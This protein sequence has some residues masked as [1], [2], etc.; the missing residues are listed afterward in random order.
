MAAYTQNMS[1]S[2]YVYQYPG[3]ASATQDVAS[4]DTVNLTMTIGTDG[5]YGQGLA[6]YHAALVLT[7]S[8]CTVSP[9][10]GIRPG[11]TIVVTPTGSNQQYSVTAQFTHYAANPVG[12]PDASHQTK[13]FTLT[14][15][16]SGGGG[17]V[18]GG[19]GG[20][21]ATMGLKVYAA[22][23][24]IRLDTK[25]KQIMHYAAYSG[26]LAQNA[27]T[28][29]NVGGGYDITSGDWGIDVT[30]VDLYLKA[31]STVNQIVVSYPRAGSVPYP[32]QWRINVFKLNQA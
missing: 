17:G 20:G 24:R 4:G 14:G 12:G 8:N 9:A 15:S 30:P 19:G 6:V 7:L 22:D 16:I 26:S 18:G 10:T 31:V 27:S 11:T 28:T 1:I 3:A 5:S 23:G 29:I 2:R 25:D 32:L 21:D 13:T